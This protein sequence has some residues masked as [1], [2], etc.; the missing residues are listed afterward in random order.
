MKR[1]AFVAVLAFAPGER[2]PVVSGF[3]RTQLAQTPSSRFDLILRHGT[4]IDGSGL[5]R[6]RA[7]V[8][9]AN[10]SIARVGDLSKERAAVE[11]DATGLFVAPGFVNIHSHASPAE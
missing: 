11:F 3:S 1:L 7:D 8:A 6:V 4:V 10:G 2:H 9:I 5:P